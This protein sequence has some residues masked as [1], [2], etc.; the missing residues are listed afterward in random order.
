[1]NKRIIVRIW[2]AI[3]LFSAMF[4]LFCLPFITSH[5]QYWKAT[6]P[7]FFEYLIGLVPIVC[8]IVIFVISALPAELKVTSKNLDVKKWVDSLLIISMVFAGLNFFFEMRVEYAGAFG[9]LSLD[10]EKFL[11]LLFYVLLFSFFKTS[12][13]YLRMC[14]IIVGVLNIIYIPVFNNLFYPKPFSLREVCYMLPF[15]VYLLATCTFVSLERAVFSAVPAKQITTNDYLIGRYIESD[16]RSY[17][18]FH[19][20]KYFADVS[21]YSYD[22]GKIW[23]VRAFTEEPTIFN[24]EKEYLEFSSQLR[25]LELEEYKNGKNLV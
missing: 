15:V 22:T 8:S 4:L 7:C 21:L 25:N 2:N 12:R 6:R 3:C 10:M 17:A 11:T 13:Y 23:R 16:G 5:G 18:L 24:S 20:A 14:T 19:S 9:V 1:M